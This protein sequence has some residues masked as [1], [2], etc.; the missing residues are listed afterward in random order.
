M[1]KHVITASIAILTAVL[2]IYYVFPERKLI[3]GS[4]IDRIVVYKDKKQMDVYSNGEV[5]KS[6]IIS[7]NRYSDRKDNITPE[8]AYVIDSKNPNSNFHKSLH[9]NTGGDIEIHGL[10]NGLGFIGK[11]QRLANWTLGCI[12][13]TDDE[14][15]E[16]YDRVDVGTKIEIHG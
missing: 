3:K 16:L 6:Y 5:L 15:D 1:T 9:L 11:F 13:V 14:I 4:K 2:L 8:G 10:K 12:A 7:V